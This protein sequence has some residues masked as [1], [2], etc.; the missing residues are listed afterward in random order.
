MRSD[1]VFI[2]SGAPAMERVKKS[3]SPHL[4]WP[5]ALT[6][7]GLPGPPMKPR[8]NQTGRFTVL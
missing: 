6:M 8:I 4:S 7:Q 5:G 1:K 3:A 2:A